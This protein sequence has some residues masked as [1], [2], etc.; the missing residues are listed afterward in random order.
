ME[1]F[2]ESLEAKAQKEQYLLA[3]SLY[4]YDTS[5][6]HQGGGLWDLTFVREGN[7]A[8]LIRVWKPLQQYFKIWRESQE[9]KNSKKI[10]F[11]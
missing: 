4:C 5:L 2:K 11:A 6:G 9:E 10:I 8:L 7:E 3:V 1:T